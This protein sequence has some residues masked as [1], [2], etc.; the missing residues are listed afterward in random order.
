M[1][2]S[3]IIFFCSFLQR[4]SA[5][6]FLILSLCVQEP[7]P[8]TV[9]AEQPVAAGEPDADQDVR[10]VLTFYLHQTTRTIHP[11]KSS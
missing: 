7:Q 6:H 4:E 1:S 2:S 8:A 10:Q 9:P 11:Y 5:L 3:R